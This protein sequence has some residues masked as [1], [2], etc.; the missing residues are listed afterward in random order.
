MDD[1]GKLLIEHYQ[2]TYELTFKLWQQRNHTF[3]ILL[4]VIG[5][6]TLL[7]FRVPQ[8]EP[9]LVDIVA[10]LV[11]ITDSGRIAELRAGFPFGLIQSIVLIVVFY[12]V[13]NL[14]HRASYVLRNYRYLAG[15]EQEIRSR[16][17]LHRTSVA[18]SRESTFYWSDR[19]RSRVWG[20]VK[21]VY[22]GMLGLVLFAFLGGR[23]FEDLW[24]RNFVLGTVDL[25]IAIPTL[26]FYYDYARTSIVQ[27]TATAIVG[28]WTP[29]KD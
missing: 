27:D 4:G 20:A 6:A 14:N 17:N 1:V 13:V 23:L 9:L 28:E 11:G 26:K 8:A 24:A 12:L 3:L 21:W 10:K 22:I 29:V 7:T 16:L 2:K 5:A 15:L 18:F 19:K 25:A